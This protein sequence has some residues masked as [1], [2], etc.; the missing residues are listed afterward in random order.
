MNTLQILNDSKA[1]SDK[2]LSLVKDST[3][4]KEER[5][6][7]YAEYIFIQTKRLKALSQ[8]KKY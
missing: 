2:L 5:N 1:I 3:L 6:K 4:T 8:L 7:Y